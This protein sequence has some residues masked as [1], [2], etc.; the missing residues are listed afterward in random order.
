MIEN[1]RE[2]L[3]DRGSFK[4]LANFFIQKTIDEYLNEDPEYCEI[5]SLA[6]EAFLDE[7]IQIVFNVCKSP[8]EK[9][10]INS[11]IMAFLS[12]D[13]F[14]LLVHQT[15]ED[16]SKEVEDFR[17]YHKNF[18]DFLEW[19]QDKNSSYEGIEEY[20]DHELS[21]GKMDQQERHF[22]HR[23]MLRY[24][25]LPLSDSFHMTL[26]PK[27]PDILVDERSIRPDIF[28][29]A[30]D[31][32]D[33]KIIVECDGFA[34]HSD[35]GSF[36]SDRKRDRILQSKGFRVLRYSGSEIHKDPVSV[37]GDIFDFLSKY[38]E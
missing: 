30:P 20:L 23:L 8:I 4:E 37:S 14:G 13:P 32:P 1:L 29:W 24:N 38:S 15:Y 31:I 9:I 19:Y 33:L 21:K 12:N 27:F 34:Y 16:T 36:I 22:L 28:F 5:L 2:N 7:S 11:L 6:A 17:K 25:Y 10:F 18:V 26:Q 3:L 35:K